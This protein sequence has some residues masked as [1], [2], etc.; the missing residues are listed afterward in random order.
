MSSSYTSWQHFRLGSSRRLIC[1]LTMTSNAA[2]PTKRDGVDPWNGK[3]SQ[4]VLADSVWR[5][6]TK[7]HRRVVED[8][9]DVSVFNLVEGVDRLDPVVEQLV[10]DETDPGSS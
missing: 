7:T 6:K 3:T 8:G 5:E 10:V 2:V 4:F 1:C 9:P